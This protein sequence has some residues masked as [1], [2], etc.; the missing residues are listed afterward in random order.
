M[1]LCLLGVL[2]YHGEHG[3]VRV[4]CVVKVVCVW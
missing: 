1:Q 2:Y 3:V 4:M